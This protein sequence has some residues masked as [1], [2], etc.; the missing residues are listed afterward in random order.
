M[1]RVDMALWYYD[2]GECIS[3]PVLSQMNAPSFVCFGG[4]VCSVRVASS[5]LSL[6][7]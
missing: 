2:K 3:D 1:G 6:Q 4:E 7:L 5:F